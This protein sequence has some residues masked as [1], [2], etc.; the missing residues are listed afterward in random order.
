MLFCVLTLTKFLMHL[1]Y[2]TS[3]WHIQCK[4][5]CIQKLLYVLCFIIEVFVTYEKYCWKIIALELFSSD[6]WLFIIINLIFHQNYEFVMLFNLWKWK[7]WLSTVNCNKIISSCVI[8]Q[9]SETFPIK[10]H[11]KILQLCAISG[12]YYS[13]NETL[14]LS[15]L[16]MA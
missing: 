3:V 2:S 15:G 4:I 9:A 7:L 14:A 16:Y 13:V 12:P 11:T 1:L 8:F 5:L 10:G 6:S